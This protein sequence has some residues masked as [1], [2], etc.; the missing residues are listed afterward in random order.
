MAKKRYTPRQQAIIR[1]NAIGGAIIGSS[2]AAFATLG[3]PAAVAFGAGAGTAAGYKI[4]KKKAGKPAG[5][6][7]SKNT[8]NGVVKTVKSGGGAVHRAAVKSDKA[9]AKRNPSRVAKKAAGGVRK[10]GS[11][12]RRGKGG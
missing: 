1:S 4:G 11:G 7:V 3:M 8:G 9:Y 6:S 10:M 5:K 2:T 12:L